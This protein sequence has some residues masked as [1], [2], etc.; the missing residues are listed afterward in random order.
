MT[1]AGHTTE[2]LFEELDYREA[3][4]I[5]ISLLWNRDSDTLSVHVF[6]TKVGECLE[7]AVPAGDALEAF[8]HPY[9][10]AALRAGSGAAELTLH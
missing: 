1:S 4:G 10:Y 7:I 3:D 2:S 8:R 9:A 6:D 5:E